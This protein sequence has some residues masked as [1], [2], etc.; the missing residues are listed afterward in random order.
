MRTLM[1]LVLGIGL[2]LWLRDVLYRSPARSAPAARTGADPLQTITGIGPVSEAALQAMG[3]TTFAELA[4]Q[5]A[6]TLAQHLN[7]H[8]SAERIRRER[9]IE[10]AKDYAHV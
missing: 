10:Q 8:I 5:D 9:W 7:N 6:D 1:E 3:I 2:G 4:R